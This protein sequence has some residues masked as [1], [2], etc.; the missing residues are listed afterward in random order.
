MKQFMD[1]NFL[2]DTKTAQDLFHN[3]NYRLSLP[4]H[5]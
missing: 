3:A 4:P 1:E 2:L 5:P